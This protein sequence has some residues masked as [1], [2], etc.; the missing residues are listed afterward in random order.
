MSS[1]L[2]VIYFHN[3][4][5]LFPAPG[6][7]PSNLTGTSLNSTHLYLTWD[8]PPPSLINGIIREYRVNITEESTGYVFHYT[9]NPSIREVIVGSLHPYTI[10]HCSV[11]AITVEQGPYTSVFTIQ[12]DEDGKFSNTLSMFEYMCLSI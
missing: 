5:L 6:S 2:R 7:H 10:Y 12:T 4:N 11:V 8:T 3:N 1:M 9:T